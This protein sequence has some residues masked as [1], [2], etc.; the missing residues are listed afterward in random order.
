[1]RCP[2]HG[3]ISAGS[4]CSPLPFTLIERPT[5]VPLWIQ[6]HLER[7]PRPTDMTVDVEHR[8]LRDVRSGFDYRTVDRS[9]PLLIMST[10]LIQVNNYNNKPSPPP[11][12]PLPQ[13]WKTFRNMKPL[14]CHNS[15]F[16]SKR[17][18]PQPKCSLLQTSMIY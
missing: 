7:R 12:S 11:S 17:L 8:M 1:M 9:V 13:Q 3:A 16:R 5:W 6:P 18:R 14:R 15:E 2:H 4:G 10:S